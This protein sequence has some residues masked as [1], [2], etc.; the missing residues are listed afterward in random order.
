MSKF[1]GTDFDNIDQKLTIGDVRD[2][3]AIGTVNVPV[4]LDIASFYF[5]CIDHEHFQNQ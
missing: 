5:Y 2:T 3:E 1:V 4:S